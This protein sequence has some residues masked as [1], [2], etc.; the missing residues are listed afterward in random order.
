LTVEEFRSLLS[1]IIKEVMDDLKED[2]LAL[3]SQT[4]IY[5]IA[6]SRKDYEEGNFFILGNG[7]RYY[8]NRLRK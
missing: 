1:N 3:T 6:E 2:M 5:S 8:F 7:E 4:Y